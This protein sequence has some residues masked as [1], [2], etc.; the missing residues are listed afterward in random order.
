M[1]H[2]IPQK[3][4]D[5]LVV[6]LAGLVGLGSQLFLLVFLYAG[7][8]DLLGPDFKGGRV[9][10]W[11]ALLC[12]AF[13][14]QHS[15]MTRRSFRRRLARVVP[16]HYHGVVY[17]I[18]SGIVLLALLLLWQRA[19]REVLILHGP[20]RWV[21]RAAF[22]AFIAGIVWSSRSLGSFDTFGFRPVLYRLRGKT[23]PAPRLIVRG[24]YRWVRHPIYLF[25][26]LMIW[27]TPDLSADRLLFNALWTVWILIGA[28]LEERDLTAELGEAYR[29]YQREVPMLVPL[30][31][32]NAGRWR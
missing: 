22:F 9:L 27:S 24:P 18:A 16:P 8:L 5:Y 26:I 15:G 10:T 30:R 28:L 20:V 31:V 19:P 1:T 3:I 14:L 2:S 25:S 6:G 21:A 7:S 4:V 32:R 13:F 11:D 17:T 12:L 29:E 23:L